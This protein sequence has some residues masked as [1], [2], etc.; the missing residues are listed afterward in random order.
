MPADFSTFS[1][2]KPPEA[3]NP[4]KRRAPPSHAR[5]IFRHFQGIL[6]KQEL[7][8]VAR[9]RA[10]K[11]SHLAMLRLQERSADILGRKKGEAAEKA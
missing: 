3:K 8:L 11:F 1:G 7:Y 9:A 4:D 6:A 2:P 10:P 5:P